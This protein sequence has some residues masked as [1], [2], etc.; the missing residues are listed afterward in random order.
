MRNLDATFEQ[1]GSRYVSRVTQFYTVPRVARVT[2]KDGAQKYFRF[3]IN[4]NDNGRYARVSKYN[5]DT[6]TWEQ[7]RDIPINRQLD[8]KATTG[9]SLPFAKA[10]NESRLFN[11]FDRQVIDAEELL[12]GIDYPNVDAVIDR[13]KQRIEQQPPQQK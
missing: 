5:R 13:M 6:M 9:S 4:E 2:G 11:L 3:E 1:I 10:Q 8:I 12:R 7:S